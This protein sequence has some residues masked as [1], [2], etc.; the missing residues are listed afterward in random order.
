MLINK[1]RQHLLSFQKASRKPRMK[2]R[3]GWFSKGTSLATLLVLFSKLTLDY[4]E[5]CRLENARVTS[6]C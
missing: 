2:L 6:K 3:L 5:Q 1:G 4:S